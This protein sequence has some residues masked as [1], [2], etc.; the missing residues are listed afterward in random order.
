[1]NPTFEE[2]TMGFLQR[3]TP[4]EEILLR[5][6][7]NAEIAYANAR[8]THGRNAGGFGNYYDEEQIT[9]DSIEEAMNYWEKTNQFTRKWNHELL[10]SLNVPKD[11]KLNL[12][13]RHVRSLFRIWSTFPPYS[14]FEIKHLSVDK[15]R[16]LI[17]NY[18]FISPVGNNSINN[19]SALILESFEKDFGKDL[20]LHKELSRIVQET[21]TTH[22]YTMKMLMTPQCLVN[23]KTATTDTILNNVDKKDRKYTHFIAQLLIDNAISI[24]DTMTIMP[25]TFS[26]LAES[27][28]LLKNSLWVMD[29]QFSRL[30]YCCIETLPYN[31]GKCRHICQAK[32]IMSHSNLYHGLSTPCQAI[33]KIHLSYYE[34]CQV[35][36]VAYGRLARAA[37]CI[38][39]SWKRCISCPDYR[40]CRMRLY[41]EF[42]ELEES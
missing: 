8:Q 6:M 7:E 14:F 40:M 34:I 42:K 15:I 41:K 26:R 1:M 4:F 36:G 35:Y 21:L 5:K 31:G 17:D 12:A 9:I 3:H 10:E 25:C 38:W 22:S 16:Q 24:I 11:V 19:S 27:V 33:T 32:D 29:K 28:G 13:I 30:R 18:L 2:N 39:N 23:F 37:R 20:K